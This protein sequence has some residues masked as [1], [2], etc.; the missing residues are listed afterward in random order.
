MRPKGECP[1]TARIALGRAEVVDTKFMLNALP[2]IVAGDQTRAV[3][4]ARVADIIRQAGPYRWVGLYDVSQ[5]E[6]SV[7]AW[8]GEQAPTYPRFPVTR[9]LGGVAASTGQSVVVGDV[10]KDPHYLTTFSSTRSEMVVPITGLDGSIVGLVDVESELVHAFSERDRQGLEQCARVL[11]P[12][13][14]QSM[15]KP[16]AEQILVDGEAIRKV[17]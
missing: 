15:E 14:G 4:A 7:F 3:K 16:L 1:G 13:F 10:R 12:L 6:I 5:S 11:A 2:P 9:G 17:P 8:S